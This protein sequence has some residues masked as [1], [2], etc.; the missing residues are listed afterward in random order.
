MIVVHET[1]G[2]A[3]EQGKSLELFLVAYHEQQDYR[4]QQNLHGLHGGF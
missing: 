3:R 4:T 2:L 1:K